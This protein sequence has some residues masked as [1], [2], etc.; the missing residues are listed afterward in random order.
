MRKCSQDT[1]ASKRP[2]ITVKNTDP[3]YTTSLVSKN[4]GARN[5]QSGRRN[6][7]DYATSKPHEQPKRPMKP[8]RH[9]SV[10]GRKRLRNTWQNQQS[11]HK[12]LQWQSELG[13][14]DS[15]ETIAHAY[16]INSG[17]D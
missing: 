13:R 10:Y 9:K 7:S 2:S 11:E 8:K 1:A 6:R 12:Q 16:M 14:Q 15:H 3:Q 4:R 5:L 17:Q